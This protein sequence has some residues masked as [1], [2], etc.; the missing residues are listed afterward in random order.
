MSVHHTGGIDILGYNF[1]KL[2]RG[3][4]ISA[5]LGGTRYAIRDM[6]EE[7]LVLFN[8]QP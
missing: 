7:R 5:Q 4:N 2:P 3:V 1:L 6:T 8:L